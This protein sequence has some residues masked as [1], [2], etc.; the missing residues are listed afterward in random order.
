MVSTFMAFIVLK[1]NSRNAETNMLNSHWGSHTSHNT[2]LF[3]K[4]FYKVWEWWL[5][6]AWGPPWAKEGEWHGDMWLGRTRGEERWETRQLW[7]SC[8]DLSQ[9]AF[10]RVCPG[11]FPLH[12][13]VQL[14][15]ARVQKWVSRRGVPLGH[16]SWADWTHAISFHPPPFPSPPRSFIDYAE[17]ALAFILLLGG[18]TAASVPSRSPEG[19]P[20]PHLGLPSRRT[21]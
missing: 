21:L 17:N 2:Y 6:W 13:L 14:S 11:G 19:P 4:T 3:F 8:L 15:G 1:Q 5:T 7:G 18:H 10:A 20:V 9:P 16:Q 12:P